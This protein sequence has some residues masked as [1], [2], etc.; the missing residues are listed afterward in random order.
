[1]TWAGTQGYQIPLLVGWNLV[2]NPYVYTITLGETK[3]YHRDYGLMT[4][5]QAVSRGLLTTTVFW[6][7]P[8]FRQYRWSSDRA[9][10][11]KPWQGYWLRALRAGLTA[12]MTPESQIGAAVGGSPTAD[13]GSGGDGGGPPGGP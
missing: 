10:Q 1:M 11:I 12:I 8:V 2:G 4:Y 13:D 3:F 9:V 5:D 7:D 6:W